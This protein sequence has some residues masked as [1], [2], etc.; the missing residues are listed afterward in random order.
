M[1]MFT[2][3]SLLRGT[4]TAAVAVAALLAFVS[5]AAAATSITEPTG[6]PFRVTL[7]A[8]GKPVP[9]TVTASGFP[10]RTPVF[11]EQCNGRAPSAPNWSP[12]IDCDIASSQAPVNADAKGV[13]RFPASDPALVFK[14]FS[15]ASPQGLFNCLPPG[16]PSPKNG[17]PDFENCQIRVASNPTH[18]TD[19]QVFLPMVLGASAAAKSSSSSS[20]SSS[21]TALWVGLIVLIVVLVAAAGV[22]IWRRPRAVSR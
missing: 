11:V 22:W 12:T 15:G 9:F 18:A 5:V 17:L 14:V 10:F 1:S 16:A 8:G 4:V 7:D 20:G 3:R 13:A 2:S 19:D 21:N 6:N